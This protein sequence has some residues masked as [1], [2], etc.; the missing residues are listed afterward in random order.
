MPIGTVKWFSEKKGFGFIKSDEKKDIDIF[1]HFTSIVSGG[2]KSL[3]PGDEV[4]FE[5]EEGPRGLHAK[6]VTRINVGV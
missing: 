4:N 1:V 5:L 3:N 2:F 6:N